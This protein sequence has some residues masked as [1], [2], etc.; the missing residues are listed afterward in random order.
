MEVSSRAHN[1]SSRI[2][3]CPGSANAR[4]I[5]ISLH[6]C[7]PDISRRVARRM[8]RTGKEG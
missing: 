7:A 1:S 2:D 5:R 8:E 3:V 6:A 4:G